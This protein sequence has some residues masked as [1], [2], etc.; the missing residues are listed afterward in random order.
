[1][2]LLSPWKVFL[3]WWRVSWAAWWAR[4]EERRRWGK[5]SSNSFGSL[6][7]LGKR[8]EKRKKRKEENAPKSHSCFY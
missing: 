8:R 3:R 5:K 6:K 7:G 1:M 2:S 4:G